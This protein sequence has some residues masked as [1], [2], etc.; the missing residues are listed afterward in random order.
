M[1]IRETIKYH[2]GASGPCTFAS[3][4]NYAREQSD[5]EPRDYEVAIVLNQMLAAR[6]VELYDTGD[7]F[8]LVRAE[9]EKRK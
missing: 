6:E 8:D 3:I 2:L 5:S 1:T 9:T 4:A 7:A